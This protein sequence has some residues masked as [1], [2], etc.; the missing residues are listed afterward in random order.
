MSDLFFVKI[1]QLPEERIA[2]TDVR[3]AARKVAAL[4]AERPALRRLHDD[5]P[6]QIKRPDRR[7]LVA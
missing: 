7:R 6:V 1:D 4:V 2:A 3:E 5:E